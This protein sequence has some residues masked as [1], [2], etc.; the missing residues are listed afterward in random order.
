MMR[1]NRR[2]LSILQGFRPS[3]FYHFHIIL[4]FPFLFLLY[5]IRSFP[6]WC[7]NKEIKNKLAELY[8]HAFVVQ[9]KHHKMT[10][11]LHGNVESSFQAFFFFIRSALYIA[12]RSFLSFKDRLKGL[13]QNYIALNAQQLNKFYCTEL[14]ND[15]SR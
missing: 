10:V 2:F 5:S 12:F 8:F 13:Q 15:S 9:T 7:A 4:L 6:Q 11:Q 14:L 1:E 3:N